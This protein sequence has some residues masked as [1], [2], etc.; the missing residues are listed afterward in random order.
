MKIY[1]NQVR[2]GIASI[3]PLYLTLCRPWTSQNFA[4]AKNSY[5]GMCRSFKDAGKKADLLK[6]YL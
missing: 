3:I 2:G 4:N 1:T 5:G 6:I